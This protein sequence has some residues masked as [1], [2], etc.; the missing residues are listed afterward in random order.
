MQKT[1]RET[2]TPKKIND[3]EKREILKQCNIVISSL[4]K[5]PDVAESVVSRERAGDGGNLITPRSV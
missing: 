4:G 3:E 1:P 2:K 5:N